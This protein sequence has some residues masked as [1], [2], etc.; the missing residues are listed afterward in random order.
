MVFNLVFELVPNQAA[1]HLLACMIDFLWKIKFG[2]ILLFVLG[3]ITFTLIFGEEHIATS[4]ICRP[5]LRH[6]KL[7]LTLLSLIVVDLTEF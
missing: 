5:E 1:L 7:K 6:I 3:R 4:A 2:V